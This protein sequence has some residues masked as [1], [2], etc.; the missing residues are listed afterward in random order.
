MST[1]EDV[2]VTNDDNGG[3]IKKQTIGAVILG[4]L[5]VLGVGYLLYKLYLIDSGL[6]YFT[7]VFMCWF[8][9]FVLSMYL[10]GSKSGESLVN[11]PQKVTRWV[12][13]YLC[14]DD[15]ETGH[16]AYESKEE[17]E[18]ASGDDVVATVKVEFE[19]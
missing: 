16:T 1:F 8:W 2:C 19:I 10:L 9:L 18:R 11:V 17:A 6:F 3:V 4:F 7:I 5:L 12:N 15:Y 13:I 14:G